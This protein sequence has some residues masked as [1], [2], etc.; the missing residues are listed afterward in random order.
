MRGGSNSDAVK[1]VRA[2]LRASWSSYQAENDI[3]VRCT[4]VP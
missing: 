3:G 2:A 4:R 1:N